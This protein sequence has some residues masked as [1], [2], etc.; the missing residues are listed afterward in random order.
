LPQENDPTRCAL[1]GRPCAQ[2][3]SNLGGYCGPE[4]REEILRRHRQ[5]VAELRREDPGQMPPALSRDDF[6]RLALE[7]AVRWLDGLGTE[8]RARCR[9]RLPLLLD[10]LELAL[11]LKGR[12]LPLLPADLVVLEG[13]CGLGGLFLPGSYDFRQPIPAALVVEALRRAGLL[14]LPG[15]GG[16]ADPA[17]GDE[18]GREKPD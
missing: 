16:A 2:S 15:R 9:R 1:C 14:R 13:A 4:H 3:F 17:P 7:L 8:A 12:I 11:E 18:S 6:E 10:P 5:L